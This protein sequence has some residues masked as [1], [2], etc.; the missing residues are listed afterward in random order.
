MHNY[1]F[2]FLTNTSSSTNRVT[3]IQEHII[4]YKERHACASRSGAGASEHM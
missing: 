2:Y 3:S 1:H 4:S